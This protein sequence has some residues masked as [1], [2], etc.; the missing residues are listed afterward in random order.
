LEKRNKAEIKLG[1][2]QEHCH[3]L[4]IQGVLATVTFIPPLPKNT[5]KEMEEPLCKNPKPSLA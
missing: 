2:F 5:P 3:V 1:L 4:I